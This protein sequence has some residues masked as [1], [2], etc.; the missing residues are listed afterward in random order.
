[1]KLNSQHPPSISSNPLVSIVVP[2][3]NAEKYL[4]E[5]L[6]SI[7]QQTYPNIEI[8]AVNDGSN[9]RSASILEEYESRIQVIHQSNQGQSAALNHGWT[10]SRGELLSYLSADDLLIPEAISHLVNFLNQDLAAV[11]AYPDYILINSNGQKIQIVK[12]P[13]YSE[14]D[15]VTKGICQPGP[16]ALF[17]REGWTQVGGWDLMLRQ[18]PDYDFWLRLSL[19]GHFLHCPQTLAKFRVHE[20]SQSYA[21]SSIE[22][23][24][25]PAFV[26]NKYFQKR[27]V[28]P[29]RIFKFK[30][31]ALAHAHILSARLHLRSGRYLDATKHLLISIR[32]HPRA[33]FSWLGFKRLLNG[34]DGRIRLAI[35]G[36]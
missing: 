6:D 20:T 7:L 36:R 4:K 30:A 34:I 24:N 14:L 18:M 32:K 9:D 28:I 31:L 3:Y 23:A 13:P 19:L 10:R 17:R 16:G 29:Q 26:I 27:E 2:I 21:I 1:M 5:S 25:E 11:V 15:L 33:L 8:I 12:A 22:K 35:F